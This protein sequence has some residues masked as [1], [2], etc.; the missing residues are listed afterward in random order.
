L[1]IWRNKH[2]S[3]SY[4]PLDLPCKPYVRQYIVNEMGPKPLIGSRHHI[5][6]KLIDL[7]GQKRNYRASEFSVSAYS[8]KIRL[9]LNEDVAKNKGIWLNETSIIRFN[10]YTEDHVKDRLRLMLD[11]YMDLT[12]SLEASIELTRIKLNL[13]ET[14]MGDDLIKKDYYR[15]RKAMEGEIFP[16]GG[17][18][19]LCAINVHSIL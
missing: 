9:Y 11:L 17:Y 15:Y 18:K 3:V 1:Y 8:T 4:I 6:T 14:V 2:L 13:P 5:G 7:L 12:K 19:K 16:K 10:S